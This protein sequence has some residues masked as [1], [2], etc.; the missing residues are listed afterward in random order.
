MKRKKNYSLLNAEMAASAEINDLESR[1]KRIEFL[2][3]FPNANKA[4]AYADMIELWAATWLERI[5]Q[6][7]DTGTQLEFLMT[8]GQHPF[9][10]KIDRKTK[11]LCA[12]LLKPLKKDKAAISHYECVIT[13][14]A[15]FEQEKRAGLN[16]SAL[17]ECQKG[18][19]ALAEKYPDHPIGK[20][21]AKDANRLAR[22]L[23][24]AQ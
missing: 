16:R 10:M 9:A 2:A 14:K 23:G 22:H 1:L 18:F 13:W 7:T 6:S 11:K 24:I 4:P 3:N 15:L 8:M 21:A 5:Q 12:E 17:A 19:A 20:K